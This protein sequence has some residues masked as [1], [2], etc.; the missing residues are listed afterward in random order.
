M[1]SI[2]HFMTTPEAVK[3]IET[4]ANERLTKERDE[5]VALLETRTKEFHAQRTKDTEYLC[6]QIAL[7][8]SYIPPSSFH[9]FLNKLHN[10]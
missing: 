3:Q 10:L 6:R 4:N 9:E 2:I 5:A 7:L 1:A 8:E